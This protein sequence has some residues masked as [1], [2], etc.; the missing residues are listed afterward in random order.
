MNNLWR[1]NLG[2][3]A[4]GNFFVNVELMK[5]LENNYQP[6]TR[7]I[8]DYMGRPILP[9]TKKI[10]DTMFN[11][12]WGFEKQIDIKKLTQEYFNLEEVY[13]RWRLPVHRPKVARSIVP[14]DKNDKAPYDVNLFHPLFKY[15][16]YCAAQVLGIEAHPLMDIVAMV[17]CVDLQS[18]DPRLFNF[19]TY[20]VDAISHGLEKFKGDVI[21]MYFKYYS[22]LMHM[23]LYVGQDKGLWPDELCIKAYAKIG[24]RKPM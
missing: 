17:I 14:F 9:I 19:S 10:T 8:C 6:K 22:I 3:L 1:L 18:K 11:L 13:K 16:Y 7:T 5:S 2:K 24:V 4:V 12:D 21:N 23:L 15:T 20:L